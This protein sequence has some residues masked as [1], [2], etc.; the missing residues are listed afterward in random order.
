MEV[1]V[2][3]TLYLAVQLPD[4]TKS[5]CT[6]RGDYHQKE[7]SNAC[8]YHYSLLFSWG[9]GFH[10]SGNRPASWWL[11][12]PVWPSAVGMD[13]APAKHGASQLQ[14]EVKPEPLQMPKT[15]NPN[16]GD[17]WLL[18]IPYFTII[19]SQRLGRVHSANVF[20]VFTLSLPQLQD[21]WWTSGL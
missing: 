14:W 16:S 9:P 20:Q 18:I 12:R 13:K 21:H 19:N 2:K 5:L 4:Y 17:F 7:T 6:K 1:Y 10:I 15:I 8:S 3:L 11:L